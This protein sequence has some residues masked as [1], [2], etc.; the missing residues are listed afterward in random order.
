MVLFDSARV[1][2]APWL[3]LMI[4]RPCA[5]RRLFVLVVLALL[6][7]ELHLEDLVPLAGRL[8]DSR[9]SSSSTQH[10]LVELRDPLQL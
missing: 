10:T 9:P 5:G 8:A 1:D 4:V 2:R 6:V 7:G 3:W